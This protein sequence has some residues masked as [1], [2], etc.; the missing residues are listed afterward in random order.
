MEHVQKQ[1]SLDLVPGVQR[2][3]GF[4]DIPPVLIADVVDSRFLIILLLIHGRLHN[5]LQDAVVDVGRGLGHTHNRQL[6]MLHALVDIYPALLHKFSV[7][8]NRVLSPIHR[9][10]QL[11][12]PLRLRSNILFYYG[13]I[14]I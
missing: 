1:H 9:M 14:V 11:H 7:I 5:Y 8:L 13:I 10:G 6:L 12:I 3:L 2:V 4:M